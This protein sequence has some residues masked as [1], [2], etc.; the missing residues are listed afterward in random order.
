MAALLAVAARRHA[1]PGAALLVE[2]TIRDA[3]RVVA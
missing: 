2:R 1:L 3:A